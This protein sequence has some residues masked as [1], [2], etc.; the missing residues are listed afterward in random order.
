MKVTLRWMCRAGTVALAAL[1]LVSVERPA[2]AGQE[3]PPPPVGLPPMAAPVLPLVMT[4]DLLDGLK[5]P[6]RWL[7]YSGDYTGRRHSPLKQ[8]TPENVSRL[9]PQWTWQAE[10]MPINR[11][12]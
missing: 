8:I 1:A 12:F 10:G 6:S 3:A 4:Q 9:T 2:V 5:H 11:G 7:T